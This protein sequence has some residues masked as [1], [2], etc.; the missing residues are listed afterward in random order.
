[1]LDE[2]EEFDKEMAE[3]DNYET[4]DYYREIGGDQTIDISFG[5]YLK[6]WPG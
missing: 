4:G 6:D 3:H 2:D 5:D 1:M